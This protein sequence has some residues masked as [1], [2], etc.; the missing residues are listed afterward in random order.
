MF[1]IRPALHIV[2]S[3][4]PVFFIVMDPNRVR[5]FTLW[6]RHH[7]TLFFAPGPYVAAAAVS[8]ASESS[9]E[10][11]Q[12]YYFVLK[13]LARDHSSLLSAVDAS[14]FDMIL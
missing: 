3:L 8:G 7:Y 1:V 13:R 14:F 10:Q 5:V 2:R 6:M 12:H 4:F 9:T 11:S